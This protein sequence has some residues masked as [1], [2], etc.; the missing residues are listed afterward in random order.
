M[1]IYEE[2]VLPKLTVWVLDTGTIRRQRTRA[3][4]GARGRVLELGFGAGLNLPHYPAEVS[5]VVGVDPS[6]ASARLAE[7]RIAN[8]AFPVEHV[9]LK[10]EELPVDAHSFDTAVSTFTLCTIPDVAKALDNVRHALK[11]GAKLHF[12]EHGQS[13][14]RLVQLGQALWNPF[15]R[16]LGGGCHVSR[17]ID[18]IVTSAGFELESL[19][20]FYLPGPKIISFFYRGVARVR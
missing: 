10:G 9:G 5:S 16:W 13:P 18:R 6:Q 1:G 4:A 17:P 3:L 8:V 15:Q 7:P 11:P 14:D 12:L 20:R 19:E 2:R